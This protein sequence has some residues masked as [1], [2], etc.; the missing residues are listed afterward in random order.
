MF[1][2]EIARIIA[3]SLNRGT[4]G[5]YYLYPN[6]NS[7]LNSGSQMVNTFQKSFVE[8]NLAKKGIVPYSATT[9]KGKSGYNYPIQDKYIWP[10]S[11][12]SLLFSLVVSQLSSKRVGQK[13]STILANL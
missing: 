12:A 4:V 10:W 7:D 1:P 5:A 13:I 8:T 3:G 11:H 2:I 9:A 6:Y